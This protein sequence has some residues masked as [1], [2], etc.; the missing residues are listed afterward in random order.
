M[1]TILSQEFGIP[2]TKKDLFTQKPSLVPFSSDSFTI[3]GKVN[4]VKR[5]VYSTLDNHNEKYVQWKKEKEDKISSER[6]HIAANIG[7]VRQHKG[8]MKHPKFETFRIFPVDG[9]SVYNYSSQG[10]NSV[11][12]AKKRLRQEMA[13]KPKKRFT[14]CH[15]Y[16]SAM[17]DPV[18]L[19]AAYKE[20]LAKYKSMWLSGDGFVFPGYKSSIESNLHPQ[21]P[22][23]ARLKELREKW[24]ENVLFGNMDPVLSR[25][26]WSWDERHIDFDLY[27]KPPELPMTTVLQRSNG[28][29][30]IC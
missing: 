13:K 27:K 6:N 30:S 7:A 24:Q 9:K 21:M 5:A 8:K 12:L 23:E 17:F 4:R 26:R 29:L 3:P 18:D 15:E 1:I 10:L 25:D 19:V 16:L 28:A 2:L 20:F 14:Y 11:E 22:D